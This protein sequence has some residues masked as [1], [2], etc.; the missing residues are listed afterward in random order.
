LDEDTG[1]G[2]QKLDGNGHLVP[3]FRQGGFVVQGEAAIR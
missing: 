1:F 2:K 3:Q